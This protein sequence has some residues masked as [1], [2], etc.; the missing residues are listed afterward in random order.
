MKSTA[1]EKNPGVYSYEKTV[2][3]AG[4]WNA[5]DFDFGV[6]HK[7]NCNCNAEGGNYNYSVKKRSMNAKKKSA[8]SESGRPLITSVTEALDRLKNSPQE[9]TVLFITRVI[10]DSTNN[11]DYVCDCCENVE[12]GGGY[13]YTDD[14]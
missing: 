14:A 1:A 7:C 10:E 12:V 13:Y 6:K 11:L 3:R 4:F 5:F 9:K 2:F 8:V